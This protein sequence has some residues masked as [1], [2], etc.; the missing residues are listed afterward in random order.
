[1]IVGL[2]SD[3]GKQRNLLPAA[4][5]RA[6]EALQHADLASLEPGRYDIEGDDIFYVVQNPVPRTVD[7]I[8]PE[9]HFTYADVQMPLT[10]TERYGFALPEAGLVASEARAEGSDVAF[11]P[12]P[13]HEC[14]M[15]LDPGSFIV[16]LPGEL[17]RSCLLIN[18]ESP[19]RK[20]VIK[21]HSRLLGLSLDV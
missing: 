7:E 20:V 3:V 13:T 5:V 15:D 1:M 16:F 18:D 12:T 6:I 4:V 17:H 9:A 14:F 21:I 11:Y 19:F 2:L 8:R 10:A